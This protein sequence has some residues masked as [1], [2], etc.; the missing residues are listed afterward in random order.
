MAARPIPEGMT[1][2]DLLSTDRVDLSNT[3][4]VIV[5]VWGQYGRPP[6][7]FSWASCYR[8]DGLPAAQQRKSTEGTVEIK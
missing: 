8:L 1:Y 4:R 2:D 5:L 3:Y 6:L 7:A